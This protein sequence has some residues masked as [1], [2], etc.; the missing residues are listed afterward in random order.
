MLAGAA[1][2][3]SMMPQES[4]LFE[5]SAVASKDAAA[6]ASSRGR[7]A[8]V[9]P[10]RGIDAGDAGLTY[11]VPAEMSD[12]VV[13]QRVI[14]PLGKNNRAVTGIVVD[15]ADHCDYPNVKAILDRDAHGVSLTPD[16]IELARW[17]AGYYCTPLGMVLAT[18]LPAAVKRGAGL[19]AELWVGLPSDAK[20]E[21]NGGV[22]DAGQKVRLS[23]QQLAS[24]DEMRRFVDAG[25]KWIEAKRLADRAG[26]KTVAPVK[27]LLDK[28]LLVARKQQT[29]HAASL[30]PADVAATTVKPETV[31]PRQGKVIDSIAA[32][33]ADGF[34]VHLIHGVTGSGKTEVY[35]RVIERV[36]ASGGVT[37]D[38]FRQNGAARNP[39]GIIVLVPEI[40]LTPQ[41][42][43]R[44]LGRFDGVAVL[45]SGLTA[46]QRHHEW[47]RIRE[48]HANIIVGARSAV[49]A[50]LPRV[51]LIIV[52]EEHESSYKQD[53]LPRYH[54]RDVAVKRGHLLGVPV[55]LG[56]A[57]PS[58]E[59]YYNAGGAREEL[60]APTSG[61]IAG[62]ANPTNVTASS[63]VGGRAHYCLHTLPD[64][65]PGL[66]LPDVTIV[67][68]TQERKKRYEAT[69]HAGVHLLSL[70]LETELHKLFD[71]P[72]TAPGSAGVS[73]GSGGASGAAAI[74][75][76]QAILLLNRRGYANYIACPDHRCG[77]MMNCENCD[78]TM[79]FHVREPQRVAQTDAAVPVG[80]APAKSL[81][82]K[83]AAPS[84]PAMRPL[85][86]RGYVQCHHCTA[87]QLLPEHC[88]VCDKKVVV[89]GLGTQ[90]VEEELA[91]K[92]PGTRVLRM[93]SDAMR[94]GKDYHDSLEAFR[95]GEVDILLGTQ[96]IA[97][98][99][100]F[101]GVRLVGVISADT[102]LHMPDFRASERTFQLVSQVAGRAGRGEHP[103]VVVVQTFNPNDP[104]ILFAAQHDYAGFA[105]RELM[106]RRDVG[107]PPI[108]RMARVVVRNEDLVACTQEAKQ[109]A[110]QLHAGNATLASPVRIRG[111]MPCPIARIA[112]FHRQQIE[113]LAPDAASIQKL[114]TALRNAKLL[115]SDSRTAVDVDP[116]WLL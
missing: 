29:V 6:G 44:F 94:T 67:D 114:L 115:V 111:P 4:E 15:L 97:K 41:T 71:Q 22:N 100:D 78:T 45:H 54:A 2:Y 52:D 93:D 42:V 51:D 38:A 60:E 23:K 12:L 63:A 79:V 56:S 83:R 30:V 110:A 98:G 17:M 74:R 32:A 5:Q 53:Q 50:P 36:M 49:F 21:A 31:T 103:G 58:L 68:L 101:P 84:E 35:L 19:R 34:G 9:A 90:R 24:L 3:N 73:G 80:V 40:A 7:F 37:G 72:L 18:M 87:E 14:V 46:A 43:A 11:R 1:S 66:T 92:F 99:L 85:T 77:W 13:G 102:A 33:C 64:R 108:T 89:F 75:R 69:G 105:A 107:L 82:M 10:E 76:G 106:L 81:A 116:V 104:A 39:P 59:S 109:L 20:H 28:G 16:L 47:R 8:H 57:T 61:G 27:Q 95:R 88:P 62:G 25:E 112:G 26:A 70:Q 113:L 86:Q 96:M 55:V 91:K 48:G 65:V